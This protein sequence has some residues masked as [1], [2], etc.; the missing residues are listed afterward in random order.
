MGLHWSRFVLAVDDEGKMIGC[1][2]IKS[3]SDGTHELASLAV[4]PEW[5]GKGVA[6]RLI[7][8][9]VQAHFQTSPHEPLYLTCRGS[10]GPLYEHFGFR[11]LN[12]PEMPTYFRRIHRLVQI[13]HKMKA[14]PSE[15]LWVMR[16]E[17]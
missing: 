17:S 3:H 6:R 10:L 11:R 5:R 2:Q 13:F 15:G 16:L 8:Y 1:A 7:E 4:I 12:P 9:L 14:A